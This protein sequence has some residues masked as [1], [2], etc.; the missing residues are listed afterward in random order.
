MRVLGAFFTGMFLI[1][2]HHSICSGL[3]AATNLARATNAESLRFLVF[4]EQLRLHSRLSSICS[5]AFEDMSVI[6]MESAVICLDSH[7]W[8]MSSRMA[9][10]YDLMVF[11]DRLRT[12]VR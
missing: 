8:A 7:I 5:I 9:S 4:T 1:S 6:R 10:L 11:T 2:L 3:F 12:S